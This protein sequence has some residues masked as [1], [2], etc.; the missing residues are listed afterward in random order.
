MVN[1]DT[2]TPIFS[3]CEE[4]LPSYISI[5]LK[6][7]D[8]KVI[9]TLTVRYNHCFFLL[10]IFNIILMHSFDFFNFIFICIL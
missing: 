2:T 7:Y 3:D 10:L 5:R 9:E 6:N 8:L 4:I 1:P